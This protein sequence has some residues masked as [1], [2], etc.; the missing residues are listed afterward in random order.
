MGIE[1][2][3]FRIYMANLGTKPGP[4]TFHVIYTDIINNIVF[5]P[6]ECN[7]GKSDTVPS[8]L[9]LEFLFIYLYLVAVALVLRA[10]MNSNENAD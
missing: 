6:N 4:A 9:D 3:A 8:C 1:I 2:S 5:S 10:Y 7:S